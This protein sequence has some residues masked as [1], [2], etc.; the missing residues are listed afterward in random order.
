MPQVQKILGDHFGQQ[1]VILDVD[2]DHAIALGAAKSANVNNMREAGLKPIIV[3]KEITPWCLGVEVL[4]GQM[5]V[6]I[7]KGKQL[8]AV[9]QNIFKL[10]NRL[11][12]SA[13]IRIYEGDYKRA[14]LNHYLGQLN[15]SDARGETDEGRIE[16]VFE[17]DRSR[18]LKVLVKGRNAAKGREIILQGKSHRSTYNK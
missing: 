14:A 2:P 15:L 18:T 12:R 17:Y 16:V 5:K 3:W 9:G 10:T 11:A 7:R 1:K 4:G 6:L 13:H 8:P